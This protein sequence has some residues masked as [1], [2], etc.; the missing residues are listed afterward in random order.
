VQEGLIFVAMSSEDIISGTSSYKIE[1]DSESPATSPRP[2]ADDQLLSL[3]EALND[4]YI[5]D[6]YRQG[7]EDQDMSRLRRLSRRLRVEDSG[8]TDDDSQIENYRSERALSLYSQLAEACEDPA[9]D[10]FPATAGVSAPT[11][12]PFTISTESEEETDEDEEPPSAA[13]TMADRLRRESRWHINW[14]DASAGHLESIRAR[15][16]PSRIEPKDG[17]IEPERV[18]VPNAKF[19]IAKHKSKITIKFHP[20]M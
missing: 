18:I 17:S 4:P 9:T 8:R 13:A 5:W 10:D 6:S 12:P 7:V 14:D 1:Y 3:H 16:S 2:E 20:A 19:F 11:P 15:E